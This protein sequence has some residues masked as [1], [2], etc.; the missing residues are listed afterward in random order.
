MQYVLGNITKVVVPNTS[1][2]PGWGAYTVA[3]AGATTTTPATT[4]A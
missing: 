1:V 3:P 2:C 4:G